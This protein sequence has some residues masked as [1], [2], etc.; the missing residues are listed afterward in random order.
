MRP[1]LQTFPY[2][3]YNC[4]DGLWKMVVEFLGA[5]S[6]PGSPVNFPALNH[7]ATR[8]LDVT[9]ERWIEPPK[10]LSRLRSAHVAFIDATALEKWGHSPRLLEATIRAHAATGRSVAQ[11]SATGN[12]YF[13]R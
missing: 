9:G 3:T 6:E 11:D 8:L 10:L 12:F 5:L 7:K 2:S 4:E 13:G 1:F